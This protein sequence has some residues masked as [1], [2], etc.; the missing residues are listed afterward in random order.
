MDVR[1]EMRVSPGF[2]GLNQ[3]FCPRTSAWISAWTSAGYPAPKLTLWAALTQWVGG[4]GDRLVMTFSDVF[5]PVPF[6]A[7]PF[8]L[9]R[10]TAPESVV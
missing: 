5:L 1:T 6:V 4:E 8:D 7:S 2:Q 10:N 9:H 3:S